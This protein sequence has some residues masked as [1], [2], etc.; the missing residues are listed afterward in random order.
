MVLVTSLNL[1]WVLMT[2]PKFTEICWGGGKDVCSGNRLVAAGVC[3]V[4]VIVCLLRSPE[5]GMVF[6]EVT[7][8]Y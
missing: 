3:L 2:S 8:I 7:K 1:M 5:F 6:G 4:V